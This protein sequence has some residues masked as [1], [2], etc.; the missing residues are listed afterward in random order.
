MSTLTREN[1]LADAE[2]VAEVIDR[3]FTDSDVSS[4]EWGVDLSEAAL[5]YIDTYNGSISFMATM[6]RRM[7]LGQNFTPGMLRAAL[8]IMRE[9]HLGIAKP[10]KQRDKHVLCRFCPDLSFRSEED[11]QDHFQRVH[12]GNAPQVRTPDGELADEQKVIAVTDG[13]LKLDL[14]SLPDGRYA[15]PDLTGKNLYV[16]LMVR[17]VRKR[18]YR[19]R[20]YTYG[21]IITGR[22]VIP[23][24]T[25]EVK[26]W[27]SDSKRLC[28]EQRPGDYYKG[29]FEVQ[30][31]AVIPAP[32]PWAKLFGQQIGHCGICGKTLTDDISRSDGFGPE[33]IKKI[34]ES[35]FTRKPKQVFELQ[36]N[37]IYCLEHKKYDCDERHKFDAT[38][39]SADEELL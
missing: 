23:A 29:E 25:I 30:L 27:S 3:P 35:Y 22:E 39:D 11:Y 18:T 7:V 14:S 15:V 20:R 8:N 19:D 38:D 4:K 9:H 24:G 1:A 12:E 16:F 26:E 32:M 21:K 37:R 28:G 17:R 5:H 31:S 2:E 6:K 13:R 33:C 36:G 10:E 34:S